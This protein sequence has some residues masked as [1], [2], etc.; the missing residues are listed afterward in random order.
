MR[1]AWGKPTMKG[2]RRDLAIPYRSFAWKIR[3]LI[4]QLAM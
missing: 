3:M 4:K 1:G 2:A